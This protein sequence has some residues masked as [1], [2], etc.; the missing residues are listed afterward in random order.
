MIISNYLSDTIDEFEENFK[1]FFTAGFA[2]KDF[3]PFAKKH[4]E[5]LEREGGV[6]GKVCVK[7]F[8]TIASYLPVITPTP[9]DEAKKKIVEGV[10]ETL[11]RG[12]EI[13]KAQPGLENF[14]TDQA[15]T[16]N[17]ELTNF[18]TA[19][20][21]SSDDVIIIQNEPAS[22]DKFFH[23]P[24]LPLRLAQ[25]AVLTIEA[26]KIASNSSKQRKR[27]PKHPKKKGMKY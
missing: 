18:Y 14:Q 15:L 26:S 4:S 3:K 11:N 20:K 8:E 19:I 1:N 2:G 21:A 12:V 6:G 16:S 25:F 7:Y 17:P 10:T 22:A 9:D 5:I 27:K 23:D 13:I 24:A